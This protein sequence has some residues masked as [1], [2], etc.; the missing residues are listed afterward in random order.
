MDRQIHQTAS[1]SHSHTAIQYISVIP[2]LSQLCI[3][4][5]SQWFKNDYQSVRHPSI[6]LWVYL[7]VR[8]SVSSIH[9]FINRVTYLFLCCSI[10]HF[11]ASSEVNSLTVFI[12]RRSRNVFFSRHKL[13]L[14]SLASVYFW[15][16]GGISRITGD[17]LNSATR[18]Y[19][20]GNP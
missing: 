3:H 17:K 11:F 15:D 9:S 16:V 8:L 6:G 13:D 7:S 1:Q 18:S 10:S 2:K 19:S 14:P 5:A 20:P 4:L 12:C